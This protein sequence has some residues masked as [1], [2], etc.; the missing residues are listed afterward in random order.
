MLIVSTFQGSAI[1]VSSLSLLGIAWDRYKALQVTYSPGK[2]LQ[3]STVLMI[4]MIDVTSVVMMVP[5]CYNM[6]VT[7]VTIET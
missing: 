7:K 1:Y 6:Q 3:S 2:R 5:Y 4:V